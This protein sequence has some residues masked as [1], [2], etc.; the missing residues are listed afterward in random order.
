MGLM[1]LLLGIEEVNLQTKRWLCFL[2]KLFWIPIMYYIMYFL[3]ESV[4][5]TMMIFLD[6]KFP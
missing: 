5:V 2:K 6:I 4:N 1:G 3:G